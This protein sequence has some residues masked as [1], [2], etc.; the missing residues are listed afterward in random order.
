MLYDAMLKNMLQHGFSVKEYRNT[1]SVV[2]LKTHNKINF[3]LPITRV[4]FFLELFNYLR[5]PCGE[6]KKLEKLVLNS[7]LIYGAFFLQLTYL[8]TFK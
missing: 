5:S 8:K 6:T 3:L 1:H 2:W 7:W 4:F